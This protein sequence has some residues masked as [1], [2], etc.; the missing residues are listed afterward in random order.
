MK[1]FLLLLT[2]LIFSICT[3]VVDVNIHA[4]EMTTKEVMP[5]EEPYTATFV[6]HR[7][8]HSAKAEAA[9]A[10]YTAAQA[11]AD[12]AMAK[13]RAAVVANPGS[14]AA[15]AAIADAKA[16]LNAAQRAYAAWLDAESE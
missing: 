7:Y 1:N 14:W 4:E 16:K 11:E 6:K 3:A 9:W 15:R 10:A 8:P 12:A 5:V 2:A 13:A